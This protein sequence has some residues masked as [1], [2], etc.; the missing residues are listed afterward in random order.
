LNAA[1]DTL[2]TAETPEGISISIRPAGFAVRACAFLIDALIRL[3]ILFACASLFS[4]GRR[5]GVGLYLI[6][7]FVV[8]WLYPVLFEMSPAAATPGKRALGL[9]VLMAN[10]LP[11]TPAGCLIRNLL[12][13]VDMLPL[14]YAFAIVSILLRRDSRRLGDLAAG[15]VVAYRHEIERAGGLADGVP[16][17]PPILLTM[18]QQLA[19]TAFAWR[20]DRLTPARAEEIASHAPALAWSRPERAFLAANAPPTD[21]PMTDRLVGIARWLHGDRGSAPLSPGAGQ[22]APPGPPP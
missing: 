3:T 4:L 20:V 21:T 9:Y 15:T 18:R 5:V 6:S 10:G 2:V 16:T 22:A 13:A 8:N 7:A 19:L 1:I 17:P 14:L 11:I 12:R